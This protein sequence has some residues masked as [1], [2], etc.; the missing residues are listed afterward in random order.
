MKYA[1]LLKSTFC[2]VIVKEQMKMA[3]LLEIYVYR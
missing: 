1:E 2:I 3:E